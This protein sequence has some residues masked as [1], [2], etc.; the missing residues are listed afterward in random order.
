MSKYFA[1]LERELVNAAEERGRAA[2]TAASGSAAPAGRRR[3]MALIVGLAAF[4]AAGTAWAAGVLD[5]VLGVDR[6]PVSVGN[7]AAP[8]KFV[9]KQG[10]TAG[11]L[12]FRVV[13]Y[14]GASRRPDGTSKPDDSSCVLLEV[15]PEPSSRTSG[16]ASGLTVTCAA[17][18][19]PTRFPGRSSGIVGELSRDSR[20]GLVGTDV[21]RVR[22]TFRSGRHM[23]VLPIDVSEHAVDNAGLPFA[24]G[25]VAYVAP[26]GERVAGL[27]VD[28]RAGKEIY[29][30]GLPTPTPPGTPVRMAP[31]L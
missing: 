6:R 22:L 21:A 20:A 26:R 30:E 10:A 12:Q 17:G 19:D 29:R 2:K 14:R 16:A 25:Y 9:L 27:I 18:A 28:D 23:D 13:A 8:Q 3:L 4:G 24:F 7:E 15:T 5:P 1:N 11:N 31:A